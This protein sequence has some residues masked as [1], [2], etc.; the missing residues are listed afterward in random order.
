VC[1]CIR[2]MN[3]GFERGGFNVELDVPLIWN[4]RYGRATL[5]MS[6]VRVPVDWKDRAKRK[7][8]EKLPVVIAAF[9]PFCGE[10]YSEIVNGAQSQVL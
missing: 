7:R 4:H 6:H 10:K 5:D 9:C 1:D 3:E 8:G 2:L